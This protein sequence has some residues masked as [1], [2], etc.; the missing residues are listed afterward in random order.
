M[1][2]ALSVRTTLNDLKSSENNLKQSLTT[3]TN[4]S[5]NL[6][7]SSK[8]FVLGFRTQDGTRFRTRDTDLNT[9]NKTFDSDPE[10]SYY[11][12]I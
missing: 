3:K 4:Q 5:K 12:T 9:K 7:D 6:N 8:V 10:D 1:L 2:C 11:H